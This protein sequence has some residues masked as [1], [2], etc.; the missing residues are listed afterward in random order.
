ML[1]AE[2]KRDLCFL[3]KT[4]SLAKKG[5]GFT[6]PNPLVGALFVKNSKI[7]S[8]GY[9]HK[10]GGPHAEIEAIRSAKEKLKRQHSLH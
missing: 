3:E 8:F 9:H 5:E 6:S 10:A 1:K 4:F 2:S 7:L